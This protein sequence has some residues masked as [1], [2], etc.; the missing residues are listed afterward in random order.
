MLSPNKK[1]I[2]QKDQG[3]IRKRD[4]NEK[5]TIVMKKKHHRS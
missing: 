4:K 3:I 5:E 1:E 2:T